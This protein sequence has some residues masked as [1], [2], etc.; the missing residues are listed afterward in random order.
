MKAFTRRILS[1]TLAAGTSTQFQDSM[2]AN[3]PQVTYG[4]LL[5]VR[6]VTFGFLPEDVT[7]GFLA[8]EVKC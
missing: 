3:K 1:F 7:L 6:G 5:R 8:E 4:Y 2:V